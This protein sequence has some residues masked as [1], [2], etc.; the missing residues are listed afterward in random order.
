MTG[1]VE[2]LRARLDEDETT[3]EAARRQVAE[4]ACPPPQVDEWETG[5][6]QWRVVPWLY[7][8]RA[9]ADFAQ[10]GRIEI[11]TLAKDHIARHDPARV[12]AD[13]AA[14]RRILDDVLPTMQADEV[15]IAGEWGVGPDPVREASDDLLSLLALP[16]AEHPDYREEWKP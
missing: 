16:Y 3:A 5:A 8:G 11:A 13:V 10:W 15:S 9:E 1:L 6:G 2:F 14:K 7:S 4:R 12:L